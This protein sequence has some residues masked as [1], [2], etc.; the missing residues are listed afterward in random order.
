MELNQNSH[1]KKYSMKEIM[2]CI[3][4]LGTA[5]SNIFSTLDLTSGF[6]QLEL[7]DGKG[8]FHWIT[9]PMGLLGCP[10]SF[11]RLMVG[12]LIYID[13]L[14]VHTDTHEKHLQVLGAVLA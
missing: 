2:N 10:E 8:Q 9:S 1:I 7:P 12:I 4:N 6:L 5:N 3:G 13:N 14:L 11:Q